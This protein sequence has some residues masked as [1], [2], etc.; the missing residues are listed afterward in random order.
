MCPYNAK[1]QINNHFSKS[2]VRDLYAGAPSLTAD[3]APIFIREAGIGTFSFFSKSGDLKRSRFRYCELFLL[4]DGCQASR[5][6]HRI[7]KSE[8][9]L[10][11]R[12]RLR[13]LYFGFEA[14]IRDSYI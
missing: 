8:S 9:S 2:L 1:N 5:A 3:G 10:F 13:V 12:L 4:I 14:D 11:V 7:R 6:A